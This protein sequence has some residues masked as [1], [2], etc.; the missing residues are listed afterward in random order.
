MTALLRLL[1]PIL[2]I[3]GLLDSWRVYDIPDWYI[4]QS[5]I[6]LSFSL[7]VLSWAFRQADLPWSW[8]FLPLLA[9]P[10]YPAAQLLAGA[11]VNRYSTFLEILRLATFTLLYILGSALFR[12]RHEIGLFVRIL[13][14]FSLILA[15]EA[16]MEHFAG[17][18]NVF[19]IFPLNLSNS[20]M[21][22]F[23]NR[24]HYAS[25]MALIIPMA[26][27]GAFAQ[28]KRRFLYAIATAAMYA[29][30]I[31]SQ[32]RAGSLLATAEVLICLFVIT[33]RGRA[34]RDGGR[35]WVLASLFLIAALVAVVGWEPLWQRFQEDDPYA[36]RR[37]VALSTVAMIRA[38]P[39]TGTGLGTWTETYP[40]Y[41]I[42]DP[43]VFVNAAH[44]DWLQWAADGGIPFAALF[45]IL[46]AISV[47]VAWQ[48]PWALGIPAVFIH[49]LID[50]PLQGRFLASIFFLI[51]GAAVGSVSHETRK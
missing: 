47:Y 20:K 4:F 50:F 16:T 19:W 32:S 41:A 22:P 23:L 9:I 3:A 26:L 33:I 7:L 13:I 49:S 2:C 5:L 21:G 35:R 34:A 37:E 18:G 43:G 24:D 28:P 31:A 45:F 17:N 14:V 46:F 39:L 42:M 40:A 25:F 1:L 38:Q 11:T 48:A 10:L 27:L 36:G 8:T 30:V 51:F 12:T 44:N 15:A 6:A 29:S